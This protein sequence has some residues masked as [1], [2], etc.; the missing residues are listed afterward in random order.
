M[1]CIPV[2]LHS[3]IT[4]EDHI[5]ICNQSG[6]NNYNSKCFQVHMKKRKSI[7]YCSVLGCITKSGNKSGIFFHSFKN[8][9][10]NTVDW[11]NPAKPRRVCDLHF[12]D[13][14]YT[15][16][17]EGQKRLLKRDSKPLNK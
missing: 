16:K 11:K 3:Y 8:D 1:I 9:W 13:C 4:C 10:L 17:G 5:F 2:A 14:Q 15:K 7:R 12:L 6:I